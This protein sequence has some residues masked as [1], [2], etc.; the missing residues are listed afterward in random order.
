MDKFKGKLP[1]DDLKRFAKEISKKLV[2][3]DFKNHRVEDPTKINTK[4]EKQVK[5]YV[6]D[7]FDKASKKHKERE[8]RKAEKKDHG[9]SLSQ[10]SPALTA[11]E[12]D[13]EDRASEANDDMVLSEEDD[14]QKR[15]LE[16]ATPMTPAD[17]ALTT[18]ALKRKREDIN[19]VDSLDASSTPNKLMRSETPPPPPPSFSAGAEGNFPSPFDS[20]T[21]SPDIVMQDHLMSVMEPLTQNGQP[22]PPPPLVLSP[23]VIGRQLNE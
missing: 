15:K 22:P 14:N 17:L 4:K 6:R 10:T 19:E 1:K 18:D 12:V 3:S 8:R 23:K 16:S 13:Q 2:Q 21:V 11:A 7:Y 5:E 20:E 9:G